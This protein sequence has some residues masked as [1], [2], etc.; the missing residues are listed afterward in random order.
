MPAQLLLDIRKLVKRG[1]SLTLTLPPEIARLLDVN[2]GDR[3]GFAFDDST[4]TLSLVKII[5]G[6]ALTVGGTKLNLSL[7]KEMP[8]EDKRR[9]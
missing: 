6:T 3:V 9:Q 7:Q 2:D 1:S 5:G 4:R 8:Q